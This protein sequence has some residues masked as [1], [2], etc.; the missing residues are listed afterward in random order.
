[1]DTSGLPPLI[2]FMEVGRAVTESKP[3]GQI[4]QGLELETAMCVCVTSEK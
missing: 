1:M 3:A 2:T 4:S